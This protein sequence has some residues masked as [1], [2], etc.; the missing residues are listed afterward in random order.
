[1]GKRERKFFLL[2]FQENIQILLVDGRANVSDN[3]HMSQGL[4]NSDFPTKFFEVPRCLFGR[5]VNT[6]L[7]YGKKLSRFVVK[8]DINL[9]K[10]ATTYEIPSFPAYLMVFHF[11]LLH[12]PRTCAG[13]TNSSIRIYYW[14]RLFVNGGFVG[15][16]VAIVKYR[17][18]SANYA[19]EGWRR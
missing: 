6:Y 9:P 16:I 2:T 12:V 8:S 4:K 17:S 7:L 14:Q 11:C 18:G 19:I 1:M 3:V 13:A 5:A 10:S 15:I